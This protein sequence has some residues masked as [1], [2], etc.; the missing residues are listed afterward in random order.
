MEVIV[1]NNNFT[2]AVSKIQ[3]LEFYEFLLENTDFKK[4]VKIFSSHHR[5]CEWLNTHY[6]IYQLTGIIQ[7]YHFNENNKPVATES[8]HLL[9]I[10]HSDNYTAIALSNNIQVGIDIEEHNRNFTKIAPKFLH[11]NELLYLNN[12]FF[13]QLIWCA[14]ESLYKL[15]NSASPNFA[16]DYETINI[17]KNVIQ[18]QYKKLD[19][20]KIFFLK[21]DEY[22]LTWATKIL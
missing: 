1:K 16:S 20:Y 2:I 4:N 13:C 10:S 19:T 14:K 5:K 12:N 15:I 6:L 17:A 9:S 22:L 18:L 11:K 3:E 21:T 7:K 8:K